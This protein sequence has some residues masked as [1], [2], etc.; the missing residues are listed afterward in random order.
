MASDKSID[1]NLVI[2]VG[3]GIA[4]CFLLFR[5][6]GTSAQPSIDRPRYV[7][8]GSFHND[9]TWTINRAEDGRIASITVKRS[10]VRDD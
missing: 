10:V 9:A 8:M 5:N 4:L 3:L 1:S 7:P 2:L 6:R